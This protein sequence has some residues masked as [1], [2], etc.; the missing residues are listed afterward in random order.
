MPPKGTKVTMVIE[1]A[2]G[3]DWRNAKPAATTAPRSDATSEALTDV[4]A[5][6]AMIAPGCASVGTR[7]F[8]ARKPGD[9]RS[10]ADAL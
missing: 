9:S 4:A 5:D 6:D 10:G 8:A 1:P 2:G 3:K 7:P